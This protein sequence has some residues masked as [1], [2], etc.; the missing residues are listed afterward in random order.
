MSGVRMNPNHTEQKKKRTYDGRQFFYGG[1]FQNSQKWGEFELFFL[2]VCTSSLLTSPSLPP[3]H[4][5]YRPTW[6]TRNDSMKITICSVM[7]QPPKSWTVD[8]ADAATLYDLKTAIQD[9]VGLDLDSQHLLKHDNTALNTNDEPRS[10]VDLGVHD[11][12]R[13]RLIFRLGGAPRH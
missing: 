6:I 12:T 11:G 2:C 13:L 7:I 9:K 5:P 4:L 3:P 1:E 8:V 10:L